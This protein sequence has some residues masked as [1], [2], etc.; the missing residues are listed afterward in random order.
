MHRL[1][2]AITR[3]DS[4]IPYVRVQATENV[5]TSSGSGSSDDGEPVF[6]RD[7]IGP[8]VQSSLHPLA[9]GLLGIEDNSLLKRH[10]IA[11]NTLRRLTVVHRN[12]K[13][14]SEAPNLQQTAPSAYEESGPQDFSIL[15]GTRDSRT[16]V[17][18]IR[19]L[20]ETISNYS[21]VYDS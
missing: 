20:D 17:P 16:V 15:N 11:E 13:D 18:L 12:R 5:A 2:D 14:G 19:D 6:T 9:P 3:A 4:P 8:K 7:L 10:S 1:D 21:A